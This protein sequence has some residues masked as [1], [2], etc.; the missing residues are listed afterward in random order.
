[1]TSQNNIR[2]RKE[3]NEDQ[4]KPRKSLCL[5]RYSYMKPKHKTALR[6]KQ[7]NQ[8]NMEQT[9]EEMQQQYP[10]KRLRVNP[11]WA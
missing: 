2:K 3:Q 7:N 6:R 9:N 11:V 10:L 5:F 4:F 8:T 1:M